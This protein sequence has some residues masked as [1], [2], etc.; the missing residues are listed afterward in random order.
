MLT[1][2]DVYMRSIVRRWKKECSAA[3]NVI[4]VSPYITSNTAEIVTK[5]LEHKNCEI[6]TLFDSMVFINLSSSIQTLIRLKNMG[7]KIYSI[8]NLHAK[9]ILTSNNVVTIGSQNLTNKGNTNI[10]STIV[11]NDPNVIK[12]VKERISELSKIRTE[13][14]LEMLE[15]MYQLIKPL[16]QE[17][18]KLETESK[19]IDQ[20]IHQK[21]K[22]QKA[23]LEKICDD[24]KN[25]HSWLNDNITIPKDLAIEFIIATVWWHTHRNGEPYRAPKFATNVY[26][27][28]QHGWSVDFGANTFLISKALHRSRIEI[29]KFIEKTL[30]HES[31]SEKDLLKNLELHIRG[32]VANH[33]G[34]EYSGYYPLSGRDMMFGAHSIDVKDGIKFILGKSG[35]NTLLDYL[36]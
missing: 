5:N 34:Y 22:L 26:K 25:T 13:I 32:A 30:N 24:I 8:P 29:N 7:F 23:E 2:I 19:S 20:I 6:Y 4:I 27:N 14:S 28:L 10:E 9:I 11:T 31:Y 21:A 36:K 16:L 3:N 17:Y 1:E 35:L 18:K 15:E 12:K 33:N